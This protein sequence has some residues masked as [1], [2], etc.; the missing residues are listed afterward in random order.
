[1][2]Y[3]LDT[4][5]WSYLQERHPVVLSRIGQLSKD[6]VLL[7]SVVS[8]G[9]LLGGIELVQNAS[10]RSTLLALY[11]EIT[12]MATEVLPIDSTAAEAFAR[13]Y[14]SLRLQGSSIDTNDMWIAAT[15]L[16]ND[17]TVVSGDQH[18]QRVH[19]LRVEDWTKP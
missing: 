14:A 4:N 17:L 12:S 19:G 18:F 3:L 8:Q 16:A 11:D 7:M 10:R 5:I 2:R 9:E 6:A 15:A 13:I 1:M